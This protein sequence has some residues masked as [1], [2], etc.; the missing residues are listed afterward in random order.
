MQ[1]DQRV[2]LH[3]GWDLTVIP[4]DQWCRRAE[5]FALS[6]A[7]VDH[8]GVVAHIRRLHFSDVQTSCLL[9]DESTT[10]LLNKVWVLIEDP[11]KCQL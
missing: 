7:I 9:G 3:K 4:Q 2:C 6:D 10:V 5:D 8:T 1:S 11:C